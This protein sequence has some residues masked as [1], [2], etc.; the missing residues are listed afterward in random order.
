MGDGKRSRSYGRLEGPAR[1]LASGDLLKTI[2]NWEWYNSPMN[3]AGP[4][5]GCRCCRAQRLLTGLVSVSRFLQN[6]P[7][8]ESARIALVYK[9]D[10]GNS[11]RLLGGGGG[12][13]LDEH[14][15]QLSTSIHGHLTGYLTE[16]PELCSIFDA[17][18]TVKWLTDSGYR[19]MTIME[20]W[21]S[22]LALPNRT[23]A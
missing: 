16:S 9:I 21:R 5:L 12:G 6:S 19:T 1:V 3:L 22:T 23:S 10:E 20:G 13:W 4:F 14:P 7:S 2:E 11:D 18:G 8:Y 15:S 17:R